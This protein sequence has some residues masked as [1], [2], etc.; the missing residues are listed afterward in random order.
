MVPFAGWEMAVQY[1]GLVAEHQAV[2]QHCGLFDISHMGV[3][4]LRGAD[5]KD[6]L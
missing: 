1:G 5:A 3:L 2:R 4:E 6:A